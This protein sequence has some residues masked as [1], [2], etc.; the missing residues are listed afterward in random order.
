MLYASLVGPLFGVYY[1]IPTDDE[2]TARAMLATS[3]LA[4]L[5]C[6]V[7]TAEQLEEIL[8]KFKGTIVLP[9]RFANNLDYDDFE[10]EMLLAKV[11]QAE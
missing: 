9:D 4:K 7:Y 2:A 5:W 1:P 8:K 11:S 6:S 3:K 10:T